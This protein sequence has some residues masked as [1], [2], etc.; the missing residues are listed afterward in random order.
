[1]A[2]RNSGVTRESFL[3]LAGKR[4]RHVPLESNG[5]YHEGP[6]LGAKWSFAPNPAAIV[7]QRE[8]EV[9][10]KSSKWTGAFRA[11]L[12]RFRE[13][14]KQ[15][16][17]RVDFPRFRQR[18]ADNALIASDNAATTDRGIEHRVSK[19]SH[20]GLG[21]PRLSPQ[22]RSSVDEVGREN[23]R[24]VWRPATTLQTLW[25]AAILPGATVRRDGSLVSH[26]DVARAQRLA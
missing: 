15:P 2:S 8:A 10:V 26:C 13:E 7:C 3:N 22:P 18:N 24:G 23:G 19:P 5:N 21:E 25:Q 12:A 14:V 1:M 20:R 6:V 9:A 17:S 4:R 11:K 16:P